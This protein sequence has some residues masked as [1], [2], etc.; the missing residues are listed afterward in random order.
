MKKLLIGAFISFV[1]IFFTSSF[2]TTSNKALLSNATS[3]IASINNEIFNRV[4]KEQIYRD[5]TITMLY[6]HVKK[7]IET[8][9]SD[10]MTYL[11]HE[12]PWSYEFIKI[13][14]TPGKNYNYTIVIQVLPYVGPHLSVGKDQITFKIGL[15]SVKLE[16]FEHLESYELP[17]YYQDIIKKK[18]P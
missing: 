1:L 2:T 13:D 16:K 15:D 5:L 14:K 3:H 10:Y 7:A 6:P 18:L 9:Y 4:Q 8:Y 17:P 11:P 12:D